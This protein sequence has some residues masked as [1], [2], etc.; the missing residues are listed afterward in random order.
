MAGAAAVEPSYTFG[1]NFGVGGRWHVGIEAA[2]FVKPLMLSDLKKRDSWFGRV[3]SQA[4]WLDAEG[5]L[6]RARVFES[7]IIGHLDRGGV[8]ALLRRFMEM[9][10]RNGVKQYA[11]NWVT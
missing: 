1:K 7:R 8:T 11:V 2:P 6:V 4:S 5:F 3:L 10:G 9:D